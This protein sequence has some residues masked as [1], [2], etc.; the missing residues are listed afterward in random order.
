MARKSRKAKQPR[1]VARSRAAV[2]DDDSDDGD[3]GD[4]AE[5]GRC[6]RHEP[7]FGA[8][9]MLFR[10]LLVGGVAVSFA[11]GEGNVAAILAAA[12]AAGAAWA[13]CGA[14]GRDGNSYKA[15]HFA[16]SRVHRLGREAG[17]R[18]AN[19]IEIDSDPRSREVYARLRAEVGMVRKKIRLG[20]GC[21]GCAPTPNSKPCPR[22]VHVRLMYAWCCQCYQFNITTGGS[23][24][25][26]VAPRQPNRASPQ[27]SRSVKN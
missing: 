8:T 23:A 26:R 21:R 25:P 2:V 10:V 18:R 11:A 19:Q 15:S 16:D 1:R 27:R 12:A 3:D 20:R 9:F 17:F 13:R 6:P 4:P 14:G 22:G 24:P 7:A 5:T